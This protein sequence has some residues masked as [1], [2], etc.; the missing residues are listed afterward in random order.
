MLALAIPIDTDRLGNTII[1][2]NAGREL[3]ARGWPQ[4]CEFQL[5]AFRPAGKT[6]EVV[7]TEQL[8]EDIAKALE[9]LDTTAV[10]PGAKPDWYQRLD[11]YCNGIGLR[12]RKHSQH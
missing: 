7:W 6:C 11:N 4:D 8:A 10:C 1:E 12:R 2:T 9:L 5:V 3:T